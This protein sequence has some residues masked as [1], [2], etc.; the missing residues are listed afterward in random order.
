MDGISGFPRGSVPAYFE[1]SWSILSSIGIFALGL[2]LLVIATTG[3][4]PLS[5]VAPVVSIAGAV[6]NGL[7]YFAFYTNYN[8]D[9]RV[10][11]SIFADFL[12]LV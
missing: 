1:L 10:A 2:S 11:A 3:L 5:V 12:W 4:S 6:A 8:V 9:S 7:C